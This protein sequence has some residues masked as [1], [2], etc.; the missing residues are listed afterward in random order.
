MK[1]ITLILSL[2]IVQ[3]NTFSQVINENVNFNNYVSSSNNDL[4]NNFILDSGEKLMTQINTNGITGGALVPPDHISS[5]R[6]RIKYCSTYKNLINSEN[7]T[8]ISFKYNS[9]L[10]NSI[11]TQSAVEIEFNGDKGAYSNIS[12]S[13]KNDKFLSINWGSGNKYEGKTLTL[14]NNRW[15]KMTSTFKLIGGIN[16][17][18]LFKNELFDL[19]IDGTQSPTKIET[20]QTIIYNSNWAIINST[21][22]ELEIYATKWGGVE[23]LD[24]FTFSGEKNG[25]LC[26]S[27]SVDENILS[28]KIKLFPNPTTSLIKIYIPQL[29]V[30]KKIKLEVFNLLGKKVFTKKIKE[31]KSEIDLANFPKNIYLVKIT[32]SSGKAYLS[33]KILK[34]EN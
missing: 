4:L 25:T 5:S 15:Y 3:V 14:Q 21:K 6:D 11:S 16:Q 18:F 12:F 32:D 7:I 33:E 29:I 1:K 23:Y 24:N 28:S 22:F 17:E 30:D 9:A 26:S 31:I 34:T 8:S 27:L 13:L 19:G 20:I 2:I 10:R